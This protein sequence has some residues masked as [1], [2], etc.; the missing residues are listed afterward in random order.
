M[1]HITYSVRCDNCEKP[2]PVV[3]HQ[4]Q[5]KRS[6]EDDGLTDVIRI[7]LS[8]ERCDCEDENIRSETKPKGKKK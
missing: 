5:D 1:N 7:D 3:L 8:V 4:I 2:L 6:I